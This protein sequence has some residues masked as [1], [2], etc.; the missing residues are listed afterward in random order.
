MIHYLQLVPTHVRCMPSVIIHRG[1]VGF[2]CCRI[3]KRVWPLPLMVWLD[4][5]FFLLL[6]LQ[7]TRTVYC[8]IYS[9]TSKIGYFSS[10]LL[11][12][13]QGTRFG[14][15]VFLSNTLKK[16]LVLTVALSL[17]MIFYHNFK[18]SI[19]SPIPI[20]YILGIVYLL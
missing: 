11:L 1:K 2:I 19:I 6:H 18:Y 9:F 12:H 10:S 4:L 14:H 15:L 7:E 3:C 16:T 13:L 17:K 8:S 5:C 20:R